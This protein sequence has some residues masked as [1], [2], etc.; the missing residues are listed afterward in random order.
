M[1]LP[2]LSRQLQ[3]S[4]QPE[5]QRVSGQSRHRDQQP[6]L[7]SFIGNGELEKNNTHITT[8]ARQSRNFLNVGDI[9]LL[10]VDVYVLYVE[11]GALTDESPVCK[12]RIWCS[13]FFEECSIRPDNVSIMYHQLFNRGSPASSICV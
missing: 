3:V 9:D 7:H 8:R 5:V 11:P 12:L 13:M 10:F 1:W 2:D 6:G 4:G